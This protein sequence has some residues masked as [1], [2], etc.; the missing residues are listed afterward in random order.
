MTDETPIK[1][2]QHRLPPAHR[3]I[4]QKDV[5]D[6]LRMG[7]IEPSN[8]PMSSP[9]M[10]VPKKCDKFGRPKYRLVLD[11]RL[12]NQRIKGD[13]YALPNKQEILDQLGDSQ[14]FST[15]DLA[16]GSYQVGLKKKDR[17]KTPF[18]TPGY[19]HYRFCKLPMG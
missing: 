9:F 3:E 13:S 6:K 18:A 14:Y 5:K 4:I 1:Y 2:K 12:V 11:Y 7:I 19:G 17:W 16:Q 8:S 15:F 10:I